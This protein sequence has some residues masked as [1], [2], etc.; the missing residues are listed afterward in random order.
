MNFELVWARC[1]VHKVR[2]L[3]CFAPEKWLK[4]QILDDLWLKVS[5]TTDLLLCLQ[6]TLTKAG[7]W[8][9]GKIP[10]WFNIEYARRRP[11]DEFPS[12]SCVYTWVKRDGKTQVQWLKIK[13]LTRRVVDG[14]FGSLLTWVYYLAPPLSMVVVYKLWI[15]QFTVRM[16]LSRLSSD[17]ELV[18]GCA[19][20]I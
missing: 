17:L 11:A 2:S 13:L 10:C 19:W 15:I 8:V 18:E 14:A 20:S 3:P 9:M 4:E 1:E 7:G 16:V 12:F 6:G 5:L